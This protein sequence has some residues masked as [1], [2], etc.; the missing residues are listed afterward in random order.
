[1]ARETQF[2][3]SQEVEHLETRQRESYIAPFMLAF[4]TTKCLKVS[5]YKGFKVLEDAKGNQ[6]YLHLSSLG[7]K[8]MDESSIIAD[9][10]WTPLWPFL[11]L[12]G[13]LVE[14]LEK[15]ALMSA[16]G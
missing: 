6:G 15:Q 16:I 7:F 5:S 12:H 11:L 9:A 14:L 13:R 1:M 3:R 8:R 2:H 4:A 10:E